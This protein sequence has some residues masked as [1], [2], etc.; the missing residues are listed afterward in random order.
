MTSRKRPPVI[1]IT[2]CVQRRT[3]DSA[4]CTTHV[5]DQYPGAVVTVGAVPWI[6]PCIPSREMVREAVQH[7]DGVLITGGE[8]INPKI[9]QDPVPDPLMKTVIPAEPQ[10]DLMELLLVEEAFAQRKPMMAICRGHQLVNVAF[11]GTLFVDIPT[12]CPNTINHSRL[13]LRSEIVHQ[14][15]LTPESRLRRVFGKDSIG[16]N[17]SHHQAVQKVAK[18]FQ[19]TGRSP[20]GVIEVMELRDEDREM[21][22]YFVSVQFH[23]ER[24]YA[25]FPEYVGFFRDFVDACR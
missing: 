22:P 8:D 7:C 21:L 18:P 1:L 20:D 4:D 24:L 11:G 19:V 10:R 25:P 12:Q 13:D 14:T 2:P 23:P 15:L 16:V 5:S 6:L 9:Y 3:P 17:S